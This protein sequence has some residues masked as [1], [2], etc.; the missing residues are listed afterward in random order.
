MTEDK[1][2]V[3]VVRWGKFGMLT[4]VFSSE[5]AARAIVEAGDGDRVTKVPLRHSADY[6]GVNHGS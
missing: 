1:T 4:G 3:W 5:A 6:D 2:Y